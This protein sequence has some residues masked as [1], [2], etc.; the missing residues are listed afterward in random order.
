MAAF[1]QGLGLGAGLIVAIGAQNAF[2]LRQGLARGPV[3]TV[4]TVC[5]ACD[6][7]LIA[8]GAF[9]LGALIASTPWALALTAWGGAA[10]LGVYGALS[11]RNA[12]RGQAL[13]GEG[14]GA[15]DGGVKAIMLALSFSL[16]NPHVYLDTV[17]LL[18]SVAA[19]VPAAERPLFALGGMTA[20]FLWFY[21]LGLGAAW[22]SRW[23]ARPVVWTAIDIGVGLVMWTIAGSLIADQ[24]R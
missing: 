7:V 4:A 1:F 16:L 3:I 20:S 24:L 6:A 15:V 5:F 21:G 2:V 17:V 14:G 19:Q 18:G 11:F 23:L 13:R 22:A 10:F 9:G 12:F 8:A